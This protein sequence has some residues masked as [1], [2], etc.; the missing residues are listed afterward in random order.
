[1]KVLALYWSFMIV[2][3]IGGSKLRSKQGLSAKV[4]LLMSLTIYALC[5]I[6][7]L[8]MGADRQ[9]TSNLGS[10]GLQSLIITV[11]CVLGSMFFVFLARK[12]LHMDRYGNVGKVV[13][14]EAAH[15]ADAGE[16]KSSSDIK[17]TVIIVAVVAVGMLVGFLVI[18]Q[19]SVRGF[20]AFNSAS[21]I[22]ITVCLCIL[23]GFVGM[24]LG[25][26]GTVAQ[27]I[28]KAG[29]RVLVFPFAAVIGT[30]AVGSI[31]CIIMGFTFREGMAISAGFGW[32][33]YAPAVITGAGSQYVVAGAVSFMHNVIRET[34]GIILIP[35]VAK[36]I[37]YLESTAIPGVA[38]MDV[39]MPIVERSCRQDTIVYSFATGL[40]MCLVTSIGVP[41][42]MS[43]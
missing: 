43:V 38:A 30:L 13:A 29:W 39:C 9:V 10:I 3:Y 2:G 22:A 12:I 11:F 35:L 24:D 36:K 1:M 37:G 25:I 32:Y 6:M 26:A 42:I 7:G 17:M 23:L 8:G 19:M 5:F 14:N 16:E 40:L 18:S 4:Q 27:N 41:I 28:K 31:T 21:S 34:A 20:A 15:V 33:T